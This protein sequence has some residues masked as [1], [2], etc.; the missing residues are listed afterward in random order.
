MKHETVRDLVRA[1]VMAAVITVCAWITV[2]GPIPFTLQVFGIATAVCFLGGRYGTLA[3]AAYLL[4]G[5]VGV[6]VFSGFRGGFGVLAG[7]TG[8]YLWGFLLMGLLHWG[9]TALF[10]VKRWLEALTLLAGLLL[11]YLT[12]TLWFMFVSGTAGNDITF[13]AAL[14]MCVLP[15]VLP[16]LVKLWLAWMLGGFLRKKLDRKSGS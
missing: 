15:F 7:P 13:E 16:D 3:M 14:G 11:C 6:P 2:P 5:A 4:I 9:V 12:G 8:G 10:G 1:A